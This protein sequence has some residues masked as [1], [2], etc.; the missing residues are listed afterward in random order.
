MVAAFIASQKDPA[1]SVYYS[2]LI[3][4]G[5]SHKLALT[6]VARKLCN[7]VWAVY[8]LKIHTFQT[9][10]TSFELKFLFRSIQNGFLLCCLY[11]I[12][13]PKNYF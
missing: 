13:N 10:K 4:R 1:L 9:F 11:L 7:I 5:K 6:S 2:I 8:V 12:L 3:A